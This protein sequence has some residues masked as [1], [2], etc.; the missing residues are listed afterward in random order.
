[1]LA[2]YTA[3]LATKAPGT[4]DVYTRILRQFT[5]WL[6]ARPGSSGIFQP[7]QLTVTALDT[8]LKE[9]EASGVSINHRTR[10]KTVVGNFARYLIDRT[11]AV[12]VF[13]LRQSGTLSPLVCAFSALRAEKAQTDDREVPCG[14]P[15]KSC[16]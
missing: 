9:R 15:R 4:V 14:P 11:Y 16:K 10:I 1:V 13:G 3:T 7:D 12:G 8:Y 5:A 2:A 6:A